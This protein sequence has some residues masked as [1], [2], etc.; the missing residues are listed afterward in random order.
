MSKR[1]I[2][3]LP[4]QATLYTARELERLARSLV[5]RGLCSPRILDPRPS[6]G[7]AE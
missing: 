6:R 3:Q 7:D 4:E 5:A 2:K 1:R